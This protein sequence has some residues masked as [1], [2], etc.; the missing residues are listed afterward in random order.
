VVG[1]V[2]SASGRVVAAT[3]DGVVRAFEPRTGVAELTL[4][5]PSVQLCNLAVSPDGRR[6]ASCSTKGVLRIWD[7]ETGETVFTRAELIGP[8]TAVCFM[9]DGSALATVATQTGTIR[10]LETR[11][12]PLEVARER[13]RVRVA[14][15]LV[16]R[17]LAE[18]VLTEDVTAAIRADGSRESELRAVAER[19]ALALGDNPAGLNELSW[20]L[21]KHAGRPPADYARAVRMAE[22]ACALLPDSASVQNTLGVAQFRAGDLQAAL[23]T[24]R[25]SDRRHREALGASL[26]HDVAFLA[27]LEHR[28]GNAAAARSHRELLRR[29]MTDPAHANDSDAVLFAREVEATFTER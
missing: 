4:T 15:R 3:Y 20:G 9:P 12:P 21:V 1:L 6:F 13:A 29:L 8:A 25:G 7:A 16:R 19:L 2:R 23:A 18:L 10:I 5:E 28:L 17:L 27:L 22:R 14:H 24:L 26:P 11:P